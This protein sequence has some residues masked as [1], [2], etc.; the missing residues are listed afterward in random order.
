M[1]NNPLPATGL[2]SVVRSG[3][4]LA[5]LCLSATSVP[6]AERQTLHPGVPEV[7][8]RLQR[9]ELLPATNRLQLAIGLPLRNK[10]TLTNLLQQL[11]DRSSTNFHR[12][13]TP[14]QFTEQFG[15]TEQDYRKVM[16][17]AKSNRLEVVGTFGNRALV[18][19]A[20]S[21]ADIEGIFKVHLGIYQ[22]PTENRRFFAPDV[23]PSVEA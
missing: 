2:L 22:H 8:A 11:Y 19:V 7:V 1:R 15:P 18:D 16:N 23:E 10:D 21:V 5:L 9:I 14:E 20:G 17:Y 3:V 12:F 6:A 4:W 13:L